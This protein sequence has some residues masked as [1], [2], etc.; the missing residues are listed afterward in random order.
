MEALRY[1]LF[2]GN[3]YYTN[4]DILEFTIIGLWVAYR[5]LSFPETERWRNPPLGLTI[6]VGLWLASLWVSTLLAPL[7]RDQAFAFDGRV[8][9]GVVLA[10]ITFDLTHSSQRWKTVIRC[11]ALGGLVVYAFGLGE[12]ARIPAILDLLQNL[13]GAS[14]YAGELLRLSSTLSYPNIA[15]IIIEITLF[16][17]LAWAV[18]TPQRWLRILLAI[19]GLAGFVALVLTYSRGGLIA[20]VV[21][22]LVILGVMLYT[23]RRRTDRRTI[24]D[25]SL[26]VLASLVVVIGLLMLSN[27]TLALRFITPD[28]QAWYQ[29]TYSA[30][31][32]VTGRPGETLTIPVTLTNTS[33]RSWQANGSQP[34]HLSYHLLRLYP[35]IRMGLQYEGERT[36]LPNDVPAGQSI[37]VP[38]TVMTPAQD[39]D[40]LIEWDMV[41]EKV[42]WF[43]VKSGTMA[44]TQLSLSGDPITNTYFQPD[45]FNDVPPQLSPNRLTLWRI[46]LQLFQMHPWFGVGPDNYRRTY[47]PYL[48]V[49]RW[50]TDIH[51]NNMYIESLADTGIIGLTAFLF[52]SILFA[53]TAWRG[54][55]LH[56]G[57]PLWIWQLALIG[58]LCAWYIH[59]FVDYFYEFTPDST[60]FWLLVGLVV[61]A[62]VPFRNPFEKTVE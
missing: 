57:D 59:G 16:L 39:G 35:D 34:I 60:A 32:Q 2:L 50:S 31:D 15:A 53:R 52:M 54:L 49:A 28:D 41:Q 42:A 48:S 21:S 26:A 24:I 38:A 36:A 40:Y 14:I 19:A 44:T 18:A 33:L 58:G 43:S 17:V 56:R 3:Q 1:P 13:R 27:P 10:R 7:Y 46:G 12:S 6:A 62:A 11:M 51:A 30:Q 9:R 20:F 25:G 47:G 5:I 4:L 45:P 37:T 23:Y 8:L 29:V 61:S 22:L 55:K